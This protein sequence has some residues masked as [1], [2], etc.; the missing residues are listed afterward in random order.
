MVKNFL[1]GFAFVWIVALVAG[2]AVGICVL[3]FHL[4]SLMYYAL[5][6]VNPDFAAVVTGITVCAIMGGLMFMLVGED[7]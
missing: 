1:F 5:A 4:L 6:T 7:Q 2:V 3:V